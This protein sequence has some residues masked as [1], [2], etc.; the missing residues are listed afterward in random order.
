MTLEEQRS[1]MVKRWEEIER[2]RPEELPIPDYSA[3]IKGVK[4]A[5]EGYSE[6]VDAVSEEITQKEKQIIQE[7]IQKIPHKYDVIDE[8]FGGGE[9]DL[10]N[11]LKEHFSEMPVDEILYESIL[12]RISNSLKLQKYGMISD[13]MM[14]DFKEELK[15]YADLT[16][17][18]AKTEEDIAKSRSALAEKMLQ[19]NSLIA[20][21]IVN[22]EIARISSLME[23]R[24]IYEQQLTKAL[25]EIPRTYHP[26][27]SIRVPP[28][29]FLEDV[30][31][32]T[33]G[34]L[35]GVA[36]GMGKGGGG[37]GKK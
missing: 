34:L 33:G 2:K 24:K 31:H 25:T 28:P 30:L 27:V 21:S 20:Q 14:R 16:R 8:I 22:Q 29:T 18:I 6:Y 4:K 17:I 37:G 23:T 12:N 35:L 36:M 19:V 11:T 9:R 7:F 13:K 10:K 26:Y 15:D 5:Y 3:F 1:E 32:V